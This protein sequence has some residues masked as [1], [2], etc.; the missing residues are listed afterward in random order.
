MG[1]KIVLNVII[2]A[3]HAMVLYKPIVKTV[4]NL[5][6]IKEIL[7]LLIINVIVYS[8]LEIL[9][10]YNVKKFPVIIVV[11]L[12]LKLIIIIV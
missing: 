10:F 2:H 12:A 3:K 11:K 5:K 8:N 7:L 6:Y 4:M 1:F 9:E